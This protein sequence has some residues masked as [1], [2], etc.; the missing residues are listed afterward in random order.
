MAATNITAQIGSADS[1][2]PNATNGNVYATAVQADGR[3]FVAGEFNTMGGYTLPNDFVRPGFFRLNSDGMRDLSFAADIQGGPVICFAVQPDGRIVIGGDFSY[4]NGYTLRNLVRLNADGTIPITG[5]PPLTVPAFSA[6]PDSQVTSIALLPDGKIMILGAFTSLDSGAIT[7]SH[8][9]R[10]NPDGSV[11]LNFNPPANSGLTCMALQPDGKVIVGGGFAVIGGVSRTVARLATTGSVDPTFA[12]PGADWTVSE[13]VVQPDGKVLVGGG[14]ENIGGGNR[15]GFARLKQDGTLD[16]SFSTILN[17]GSSVNTIALQA[18]GRI[19]LGGG[20]SLVNGNSRNNIARVLPDGALDTTF[21]PG[22]GGVLFGSAL[23]GDGRLVVTGAFQ[24]EILPYLQIGGQQRNRIARLKNDSVVELITVPSLN[25]ITWERGGA[26]PE[27]FSVRF[28]VSTNDGVTWSVLGDGSRINGGWQLT[29]LALPL[30]GIVRGVATVPVNH[31]GG[32]S[33]S[34]VTSTRTYAFPPAAEVATLTATNPTTTSA[35]LNATIDPNGSATSAQFQYGLTTAYGSTLPITLIPNDGTAAQ[36]IS[37]AVTSLTARKTYHYRVVATNAFGTSYGED[38]TFFTNAMPN[39][40][41]LSSNTIAEN[42]PASTAVGLLGAMTDSDG[43]AISYS[44]VTGE[45]DADNPSFVIVG[46]TLRSNYS[47]DY[48]MQ[49]SYSVRVRAS[50][51]FLNGD[52]DTVLT[53]T[54]TNVVEPPIV[55]TMPASNVRHSSAALNAQVNPN[56]NFTTV[57]FEWGS[58]ASYGNVAPMISFGAMDNALHDVQKYIGGLSIGGTFH[59]RITATNAEGSATGDDQT[60]TTRATSPGDMDLAF[61]PDIQGVVQCMAVQ[62]NGKILVGGSFTQV[63]GVERNNLAR[64]NA[65]GTLD[66]GFN[67]NPDGAVNCISVQLDGR[68]LIGGPF[69]AVGAAAQSYLARLTPTGT[70]D[71]TFNAS[72]NG[73]VDV[74]GIDL[75]YEKIYIAGTFTSVSGVVLNGFARLYPSGSLDSTLPNLAPNGPILC[76][77]FDLASNPSDGGDGS[78]LVGGSFS[79]IGGLTY[80]GLAR[81]RGSGIS[82]GYGGGPGVPTMDPGTSIN[83]IVRGDNLF[84]IGGSYISVS[85]TVQS[86]LCQFTN[87]GIFRLWDSAAPP[88]IDGPVLSLALQSDGKILFGGEFPTVNG[89]PF[90]SLARLNANG[91]LDT[92]F[93]AGP[94]SPYLNS[95]VNKVALQADGRVLAGGSFS[96]FGGE[97]RQGFGRLINNSATHHLTAHLVTSAITKPWVFSWLFEGSAPLVT[98]ANL[99]YSTDNGTTWSPAAGGVYGGYYYGS[100][101]G[102]ISSGFYTG[103]DMVSPRLWRASGYINGTDAVITDSIRYPLGTVTDWRLAYFGAADGAGS[104]ADDADPDSDGVANLLEYAFGSSPISPTSSS[105]PSGTAVPDGSGGSFFEMRFT[106]PPGITGIIYSGQWSPTLGAGAVWTAVPDTG[107]APEHVFRIAITPGIP[108]F[109][110]IAVTRTP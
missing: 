40:P 13:I 75:I 103:Q 110:R 21:N 107:V 24:H 88:V 55:I 99:E 72:I 12:D 1:F 44:L 30:T 42:Q 19:I 76:M 10:L 14:F 59:Y 52:A 71:T 54:V 91:T 84:Y 45:G 105:T 66:E 31:Q 8:I 67:P 73:S 33:S 77:A 96:H 5:V 23:L 50:D 74:L 38:S 104:S 7:R 18:N 78:V 4:A 58:T 25:E 95:A 94:R 17:S 49:A 81:I 6:R 48:E 82:P 26:A 97:P 3:V 80:H 22:S 37:L 28:E 101:L 70:L 47:F 98:F 89:Q 43:D 79:R 39:A 61:N 57:Q 29:G 11:D 60:F 68:I 83:A 93:D 34:I 62:P 109:M 16:G 102:G 108:G 69:T 100:R 87:S 41:A 56:S 20:F 65:D 27:A 35:T 64:V 36:S 32:A 46:N 106:E 92:T 53:I 51:G 90:A 9:A 2:D 15:P 85:G 86:N 63:N